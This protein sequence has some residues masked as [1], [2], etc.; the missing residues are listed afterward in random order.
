MNYRRYQKKIG[1]RTASLVTLQEQ[2]TATEAQITSLKLSVAEAKIAKQNLLRIEPL[3]S[4]INNK[5]SDLGARY[6][7][8]RLLA[9]LI[10]R[11]EQPAEVSREI[12]WLKARRHE[13]E[14]GQYQANWKSS[15]LSGYLSSIDSKEVYLAKLHDAVARKQKKKNS[16][17]ELRAAAAA[18]SGEARKVGSIV[19]RALTE[20]TICPYCGGSL[21]T[22][23]HADHIYP[24]SKGGRSV[25]KNM[26]FT[27]SS[28]NGRKRDLTLSNFIRAF[29][30]NRDEIEH[31]LE[32]LGK[33]F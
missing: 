30:L 28:C 22:T 26:V 24:I 23:P 33:E 4:D 17:I 3:I 13:L 9:R 11:S 10:G 7:K 8:P 18:N 20:Q 29:R 5:L 14:S 19:R 2:I 15:R 1:V 25:P 21:G 31:R 32:Q 16:I 12:E 6:P 27:C